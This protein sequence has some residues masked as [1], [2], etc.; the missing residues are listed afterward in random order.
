[1][2][3]PKEPISFE[4]LGASVRLGPGAV[5]EVGAFFKKAGSKKV[6]IATDK[7]VVKAGLVK[8]SLA[9]LE[10]AQIGYEIFDEIEPNPSDRTVMAGAELFKKT[11]CQAVLGVG[12]GSALDAGKAIQV[13]AVHPG[14]VSEYFG[15]AAASRS[16][17]RSPI[18]LPF[19]QLRE[20]ARR[21]RGVALSR[22]R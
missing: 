9:S 21:F 13:M 3:M 22:T 7:G 18:T 5:Q 19:P 4:V 14:H 1:M 20:P 15:V 6:F 17:S 2:A 8:P 11:G 12:G 16:T 10:K